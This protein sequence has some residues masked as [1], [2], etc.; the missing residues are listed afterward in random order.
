MLKCFM[1]A[2]CISIGTIN[3]A[4]AAIVT[5]DFSFG[6]GTPFGGTV[7]VGGIDVILT[8]T[9][10][11]PFGGASFR[12][13]LNTDPSLVTF[14]FSA[15]VSEFSLTISR[16]LPPDEFLTNFNIGNPTSLTGD[17]I[18]V[19]GDITSSKPGDFGTGSLFWSGINTSVISFTIGNDPLSTASPALAL[20]EFGISG[21]VS[22]VPV[23]AAVWLF[24]SGLIGL[25][26]MKRKSPKNSLF[27]A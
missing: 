12:D 21:N 2:V 16:V 6:S 7:T 26:G 15:P 25:I 8:T 1:F 5:S 27:P 11:Q 17:L 3:N 18:N 19:G 24:G 20:D 23:P 14:E 13:L 9:N 4:S 10:T 22:E